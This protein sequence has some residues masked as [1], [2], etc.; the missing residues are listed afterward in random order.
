MF[1]SGGYYTSIL[2]SKMLI[3]QFIIGIVYSKTLP[4]LF[5]VGWID[6]LAWLV[7]SMIPILCLSML[8]FLAHDALWTF[9]VTFI[10]RSTYARKN[11]LIFV[12]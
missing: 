7:H 6:L 12:T 9:G 5:E 3:I 2:L 11:F 1:I 10:P 4:C 8:K